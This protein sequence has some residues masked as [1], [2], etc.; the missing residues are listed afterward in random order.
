MTFKTKF[1]LSTIFTSGLLY[2]DVSIPDDQ[3]ALIVAAK[4]SISEVKDFVA[5]EVANPNNVTVYLSVSNHYGV[6]IGFLKDYEKGELPLAK[7]LE[8]S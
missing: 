8:A 2:G 1:L 7:E 6:A 4:S 3:C 5:N